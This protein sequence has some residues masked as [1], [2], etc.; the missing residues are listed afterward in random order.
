MHVHMC[1][2][3][4]VHL[5]M[6]VYVCVHVCMCRCEQVSLCFCLF[7]CMC[8]YMCVCSHGSVCTYVF[9]YMHVS[10]VCVCVCVVVGWMKPSKWVSNS[11]VSEPLIKSQRCEPE[12]RSRVLLSVDS[13]LTSPSISVV[14]PPSIHISI[15]WKWDRQKQEW[16]RNCL[17]SKILMASGYLLGLLRA[18]THRVDG[19]VRYSFHPHR[20]RRN[21]TPKRNPTQRGWRL[22]GK[23]NELS[24]LCLNLW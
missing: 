20:D 16:M 3:V 6:C 18:S 7:T 14:W 9:T 19:C 10:S 23:K 8:V 4:C 15:G 24:L 12:E 1:P 17:N 21:P 22:W 11:I 13:S 2:H 5:Y